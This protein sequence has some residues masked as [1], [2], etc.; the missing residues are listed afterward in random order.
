MQEAIHKSGLNLFLIN[1]TL[2]LTP[3]VSQSSLATSHTFKERLLLFVTVKVIA[4]IV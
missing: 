1:F 2:P 3:L 4:L